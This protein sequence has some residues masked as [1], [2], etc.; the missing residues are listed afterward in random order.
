MQQRIGEIE[1]NGMKAKGRKELVRHL[2]GRPL[3]RGQ[4]IIAK[5]YECTGYYSDG[6]VDCLMP[7]C[8]LYGFMVYRDQMDEHK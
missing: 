8:P 4:A 3:Q 2:E 6:K 7:L 1:K 5:C